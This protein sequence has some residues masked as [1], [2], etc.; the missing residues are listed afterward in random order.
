MTKA[1]TTAAFALLLA[2]F[3]TPA[4][5]QYD[6]PS[7]TM[8]PQ[9][10]PTAPNPAD[11]KTGITRSKQAYKALSDLQKA[12]NAN[13]TAN[14]PAKLAAAQATATTREDKYLVA[15]FQIKIAAAAHDIP[16]TAAA[17]DAIAAS[18]LASN[19]MLGPLYRAVGAQYYNGKQFDRAT[20]EFER[21]A[22]LLPG[23]AETLTLLGQAHV[24]LGQKA[25]AVAAFQRALQAHSA[26]GRKPD[27][28]LYKFAVQT[29]YDA[30]LPVA[31]ELARQW[32]GA[33]PSADSWHN[34]VAVYRSMQRPESEGTVDLLRLL[35]AAGA[36]TPS[37]YGL[38]ATAVAAA[39]NFNEAQSVIDQGIASAKIQPSS[40]SVRDLIAALKTKQKATAADLEVA[41]KSATSGTALIG[42]G[43]RYYAM[44]EYAKAA[45]MYRRSMGKS[46]D[47]NVANLHL[48]M[49]LARGGDKTGAAAAL[50]AVTGPLAD[51]AKFWLLYLQTRA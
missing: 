13:D 17:V 43:D 47:P 1:S 51:V 23:D 49:A 21:A 37:D 3:A 7:G 12:V 10:P 31:V 39:G 25:E 2:V 29:A 32:V 44:G 6:A 33:Y 9:P 14:I 50:N 11:Q 22:A 18:G 27:E 36:M 5:A 24:A 34:A 26:A 41:A 45:D 15:Q 30:R 4:F 20:A 16:G 40:P 42:I 35:N 28:N 19:A 8:M 48:G 38:Y 46:T